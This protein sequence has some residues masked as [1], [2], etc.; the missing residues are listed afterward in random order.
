MD[1]VT[2]G[3]V[4]AAV[5][6]G[7]GGALGAQAW[8]GVSGLVRRPFRHHTGVCGSAALVTG[9]AELAALEDSPADQE[10]AVALAEVLLARAGA[11]KRFR[12]A[13][14]DWWAQAS[15]VHLAGNVTN[16]ISGGEFRGPVLQGRDFTNLS[17]G[18]AAPAGSAA[19]PRDEDPL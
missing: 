13:L 6:G 9:E 7:A 15:Q 5:V 14:E 11:D 12:Q 1:P 10:R 8:A 17:F 3:A 18:S 2:I 4:L 19:P 16:T